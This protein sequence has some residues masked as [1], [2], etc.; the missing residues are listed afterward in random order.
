MMND[1]KQH[2]L[3]VSF[4]LF[5]QKNFK[6]VTMQEIVKET[7][8]SKGAFYHYFKSKEKL[9]LEVVET[10]YLAEEMLN[11][12]K[13]DKNSLKKFY[14]SYITH[15]QGFI[16]YLKSTFEV[17]ANLAKENNINYFTLIFDAVG[18][19]PD[20]KTKL[21]EIQGKEF[22]IWLEVIENAIKKEEI[23]TKMESKY[24]ARMFLYSVDATFIQF[25][26][27]GKLSEAISEINN[28]WNSFY[29]QLKNKK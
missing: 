15:L 18:R 10:F 23:K 14:V 2:I 8:L 21:N 4:R 29:K 11:Y 12:D 5:L 7:G 19:F 3:K 27:Q 1:T 6:E 26:L 16:D 13:L 20:F 17:D 28:L 25:I 22:D 9:F 24:I